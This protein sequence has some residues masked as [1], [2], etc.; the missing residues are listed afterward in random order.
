MNGKFYTKDR[1]SAYALS[2]GY[3]ET[4]DDNGVNTTLWR[5]H[6]TYHVRKHDHNTGKRIFWESF[7]KLNDARRRFDM[8]KSI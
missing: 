8:E 7:R 5:E 3:L 1:L 2:C 4:I 6:G